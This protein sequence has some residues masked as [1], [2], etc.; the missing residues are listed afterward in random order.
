VERALGEGVVLG[1]SSRG[2]AVEFADGV[3]LFDLKDSRT[4]HE[5]LQLRHRPG[6]VFAPAVTRGGVQ[7]PLDVAETACQVFGF[8]PGD[9]VEHPLLG[10][11]TVEG[12]F[13]GG[14][15]LRFDDDGG[16][17]VTSL[18]NEPGYL[19]HWLRIVTPAGRTLKYQTIGGQ[20]WPVEITPCNALRAYSLAPGDLVETGVAVGEIVGSFRH[21]AVV[22]NVLSG[23]LSLV[24]PPGLLLLRHFGE[25]VLVE[26]PSLDGGAVTIDVSCA[27]DDEFMPFDRVITPRG[28]ATIVGKTD[29]ALW[30]VTDD[31]AALGAGAGTLPS[32]AHFRLVRRIGERTLSK[33]GLSVAS[34]DFIGSPVL[35]DDEVLLRGA[36]CRILGMNAER[37]VAVRNL[38][39]DANGHTQLLPLAELAGCAIVYRADLP[40]SR[41]YHSKAGTRLTLSVSLRDF[42]GKRFIPDDVLETPKGIGLVVGVTDA[43]VAIHLAGDDGVCFFTPQAIY[44]VSLFKLR[45]RRAIVSAFR[46]KDE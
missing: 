33:T 27:I 36:R 5:A 12:V 7:L 38:V 16:A 21:F 14:L 13:G 4:L 25:R 46:R 45:Q 9:R 17:I 40:A 35:P 41:A 39:S 8:A 6:A 2:L 20:E 23:E 3:R 11:A 18:V 34:V 19:H 15:W 28:H 29:G 1:A 22:E 26:R 30:L 44:D 24:P 43:N 10:G 42:L 32:A 37:F 31:A